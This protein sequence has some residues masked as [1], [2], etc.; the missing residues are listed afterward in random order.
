MTTKPTETP[1]QAAPIPAKQPRPKREQAFVDDWI[2]RR[3]KGI[4]KR[5]EGDAEVKGADAVLMAVG[6]PE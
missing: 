1:D 2:A 4:A 3:N 6:W 5:D